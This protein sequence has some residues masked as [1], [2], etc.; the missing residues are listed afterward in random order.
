MELHKQVAEKISGSG[1]KIK[2]IVIDKLAEIEVTRRAEILTKA[3]AKHEQ[4][5]KD[6]AKIDG[7][8]DTAHYVADGAGGQK[9]V[10]AMSE[11]RFK[12][13]E[14]AKKNL[15]AL[16]KAIDEALEKNESSHWDTLNKKVQGGGNEKKEGN[17]EEE[18]A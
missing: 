17:K 18:Q 12:Q 10:E 3:L 16:E 7:K 8:N 5:K 15:D 13:I 1:E 2:N 4:A 6:F 11:A 14:S 9:K